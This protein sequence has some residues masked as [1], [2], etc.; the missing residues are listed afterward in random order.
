MAIFTALLASGCATF[1]HGPD[2]QVTITTEPAG[3]MVLSKGEYVGTTP[4]AVRLP[5]KQSHELTIEKPDYYSEIVT[6]ESVP[7][8]EAKAYVRYDFDRVTGADRDLTP[9]RIHAPLQPLILPKEPGDDPVG[10]LASHI[11][12]IDERRDNGEI[13]D[14]EHRYIISRLFEFYQQ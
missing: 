4:L 7:N 3:A 1:R 14:S 12:E 6:I 9:F 8:R 11:L 5:R 2:Q 10:D 13:D